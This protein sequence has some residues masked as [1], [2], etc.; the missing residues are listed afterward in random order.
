MIFPLLVV[1]LAKYKLRAIAGLSALSILLYIAIAYW[2]PRVNPF[3]PGV[4]VPHD[5]NVTYDYGWVRGIAGFVAG[6]ILY[7]AYRNQA[8]FNFFKRDIISILMIVLATVIFHFG[9]N[10]LVIAACFMPLILAVATNENLIARLFRL[11]LP[12]YFGDISYSIYLT[13]IFALF[14]FAVPLNAKLGFVASGQGAIPVSFVTGLGLCA[15]YLLAV[16]LISSVTYYLIER[17]CRNWL[18]AKFKH[19]SSVAKVQLVGQ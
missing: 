11:R 18:N 7:T 8:I 1:L 15:L 6:M 13:H 19:K 2:L 16:V 12:Q 5:L 9:V 3:A 17:P 10:D 14:Y 4:P